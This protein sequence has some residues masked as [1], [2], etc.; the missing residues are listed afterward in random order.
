MADEK[1]KS[2]ASSEW[3]ELL[4][5]ID[6]RTKG[7]GGTIEGIKQSMVTQ[8][9]FEVFATDV[10]VDMKKMVTHDEFKPFKEAV[11]KLDQIFVTKSEHKPVRNIAYGVVTLLCSGVFLILIAAL[12]AAAQK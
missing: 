11:T 7:F 4:I 12:V 2:P 8:K 10:R 1:Q 9:E 5:R 3:H 6:E